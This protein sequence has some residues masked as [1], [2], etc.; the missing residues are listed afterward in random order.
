[1]RLD[2]SRVLYVCHWWCRNR[3]PEKSHITVVVTRHY[4]VVVVVVGDGGDGDG[5]LVVVVV[6]G[7][8]YF[9]S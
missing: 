2:S 7:V 3:H 8:A 5:R 1:M 4:S 9:A 6:V